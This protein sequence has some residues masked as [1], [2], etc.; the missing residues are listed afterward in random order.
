[1]DRDEV[2]RFLKGQIKK[3]G[4]DFEVSIKYKTDSGKKRKRQGRF[5]ELSGGD[6]LIL[7][8]AAKG[9]NGSYEVGRISEI[10]KKEA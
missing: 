4:D 7:F 10:K 8:N 6:M 3:H 1:M 2:L 5:V 9:T